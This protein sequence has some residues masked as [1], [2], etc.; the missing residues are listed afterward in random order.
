M[1]TQAVFSL[2]F[3][4]STV[5]DEQAWA[6]HTQA[7]SSLASH[8]SSVY[9]AHDAFF[10]R[11]WGVDR[12]IACRL[13]GIIDL[14]AKVMLCNDYYKVTWKKQR[15]CL[16]Y[17]LS[18]VDWQ[19]EFD[20]STLLLMSHTNWNVAVSILSSARTHTLKTHELP[21]NYM[22]YTHLLKRLARHLV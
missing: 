1:H 2:A 18:N 3:H 11:A 8:C 16:R 19:L 14:T 5:S 20:K 4:C 13:G 21:L 10:F 15:K 6:L 12:P 7:V 9:E 17:L 22:K